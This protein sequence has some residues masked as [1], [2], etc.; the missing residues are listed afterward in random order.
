MPSL[1][2]QLIEFARFGALPWRHSLGRMMFS[3]ESLLRQGFRFPH[4]IER[5][6]A[7]MVK[8]GLE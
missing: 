1:I 3:N 5:L 2:D 4:G 7:Q 6:Y 8:G